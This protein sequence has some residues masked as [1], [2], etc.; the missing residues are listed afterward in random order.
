ML[1]FRSSSDAF[2]ATDVRLHPFLRAGTDTEA[3]WRLDA[4]FKEHIRP[5]CEAILKP[6]FAAPADADSHAE[7]QEDLKMSATS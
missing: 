4:V 1:F 7:Q 5:T 6:R 2:K 3:E